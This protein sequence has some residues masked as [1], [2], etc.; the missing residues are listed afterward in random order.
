MIFIYGRNGK[1]VKVIE[2]LEQLQMQK[3][4]IVDMCG[5]NSPIFS[6]FD[7]IEFKNQ[8]DMWGHFIDDKYFD[9]FITVAKEYDMVVF[10]M[11]E[12]EDWLDNY[13]FIERMIGKEILVTARRESEIE[14]VD[15]DE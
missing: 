1:S 7:N 2:I 8:D 5:F 13:A 3:V 4:L 9:N 15:F 6:N 11:N 12:E 14:V 10:Y